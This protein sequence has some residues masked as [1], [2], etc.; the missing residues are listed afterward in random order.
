[1][2][3]PPRSGL[4]A[5][6]GAWARARGLTGL[7]GPRDLIGATPSG[8]LVEGFEHAPAMGVPYNLPY[9]DA[10]LKAAGLQKDSDHVSGFLRGDH[11]LSPRFWA[12]ADKVKARRGLSVKSFT[13][14]AEM[15]AWIPRVAKV[16]QEGF[17][18]NYGYYP[19]TDD[20]FMVAGNALIDMARPELMQLVVRGD[21]VVGFLFAYPNLGAGLR[22]ARG[23]LWPLGWAHLLWSQRT[24]RMLDI[25]G[26][27]LLPAVQGAGA[28]VMLYTELW[29]AAQP[30]GFEIAD[31]V[32][33]DEHNDRSRADMEAIGVQWYKRHRSYWQSL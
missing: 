19:M 30:F 3:P 4:F 22:R 18:G 17:R 8:V 21:E 29:R 26:V 11:A 32:A 16:Y 24:T 15:R 25:N 14:K 13:S 2:I 1:M 33:V 12:V 28:N 10:L 27:G 6:A 9:Y 20:E 5:A 7:R 31:V 23:R